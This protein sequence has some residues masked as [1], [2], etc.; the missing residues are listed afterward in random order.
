MKKLIAINL[1]FTFAFVGCV[2]NSARLDDR[3]IA[4]DRTALHFAALTNSVKATRNALADGVSVDARDSLNMTSLH[5]AA[6]RN[7]IGVAKLLIAHDADVDAEGS[8]KVMVEVAFAQIGDD[9]FADFLAS[10]EDVELFLTPLLVAAFA[11]SLGVAELL[12]ANGAD[13]DV[14]FFGMTAFEFAEFA[15]N[16]KMLALLEQYE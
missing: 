3:L 13:V 16:K 8:A 11:N 15:E 12:L 6:E 2:S 5:Y 14:E 1:I 10:E 7:S 4:K 9:D